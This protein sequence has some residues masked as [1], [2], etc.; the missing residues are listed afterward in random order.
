MSE[1]PAQKS[2]WTTLE[3]AKL[4]VPVFASIL[5]AVVGFEIST[6]LEQYKLE[7]NETLETY[8]SQIQQNSKVI[9]HLME[10]NN[11]IDDSLNA[12]RVALYDEIGRKLNQM[13]AYYMYIG[14]WKEMSPEDIIKHKRDLDEIVYTYRPIF[15]KDFIAIYEGLGRQMFLTYG[16][17]G[18]DA[19]LR[20]SI[21]HRQEFYI[22]IDTTKVWNT[23]WD[24]RFTEE[25]NTD[26][27]ID[28]Y[29]KLISKLPGELGFEKTRLIDAAQ[30]AKPNLPPKLD[31]PSKN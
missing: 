2:P 4:S 9:D 6:S 21:S 23:G 8:K 15:S 16:E 30:L 20:T 26:A 22:P 12:K 19:K 14:K 24:K 5:L 7:L 29:S 11:K 25:D 17:W 28:Q 13:Y 31:P 1:L 10:R 18:K 3:V 27:I